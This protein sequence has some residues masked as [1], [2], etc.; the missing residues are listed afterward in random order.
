MA[1]GT[2]YSKQTV[3][4]LP[5]KKSLPER[6]NQ[7]EKKLQLDGSDSEKICGTGLSSV[8]HVNIGARMS[9]TWGERPVVLL[10]WLQDLANVKSLTLSSIT[11]Q[12]LSLVPDLLEIKLHSLYGIVSFLLQNSPLAEVNIIT[13]Y[14]PDFN[15]KQ[16]EESLK[17]VK[18]IKYHLPFNA[19]D[20]SSTEPASP[21][22]SDSAAAS[23]A[24]PDSAAPPNLHLYCAEKDDKSSNEDKHSNPS[25]KKSQIHGDS[26]NV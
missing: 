3:P 1:F 25:E 24:A 6:S 14:L 10:S 12:I 2:N 18:N 17:G 22:E 21:A 26:E 13:D 7:P 23:A 16:A 20:S 4:S 5:E 19:P 8:K 9:P 15:I 11:L